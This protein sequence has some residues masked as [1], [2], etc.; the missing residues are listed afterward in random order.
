MQVVRREKKFVQ[1][2]EGVGPLGSGIFRL[3]P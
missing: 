1:L 2:L 3:A